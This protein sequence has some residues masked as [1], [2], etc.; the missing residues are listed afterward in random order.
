MSEGLRQEC[1]EHG[2]DVV[3]VNP[4]F[5]T[6]DMSHQFASE[7]EHD[8]LRAELVGFLF[9]VHMHTDDYC[10]KI[11]SHLPVEELHK[12]HTLSTCA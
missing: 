1:E 2:V 10:L 12:W 4:Y 3:T 8:K 7:S 9:T 6:S 5:I 11:S